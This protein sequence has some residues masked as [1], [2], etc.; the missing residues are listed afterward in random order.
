MM[1][2]KQIERLPDTSQH[3]QGEHVDLED[4]EIVDVVLVPLDEAAFGHRAIAD[5]HG[6]DQRSVGENEAADML[7]E[8]AR[9]ADHLAGELDDPSQVRIGKIEP[10]L[11][12]NMLL[13]DSLSM[14]APY[15][16][17]ERRGDVFGKS[18]GLADLADSHARPVMDHRGAE[19]GAIP[20]V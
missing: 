8:V 10:R 20:T 13:V 17:R 12:K 6:L 3:P 7:A 5:G 16:T 1:L 18:H 4:A 9:H 19:A 14:A 2:L 15:G 11:T